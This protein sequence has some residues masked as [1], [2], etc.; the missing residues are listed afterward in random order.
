MLVYITTIK[1][2]QR[3]SDIL[4]TSGAHIPPLGHGNVIVTEMIAGPSLGEGRGSFFILNG[5]SMRFG[6]TWPFSDSLNV[7]YFP[8]RVK[9]KTC[10]LFSSPQWVLYWT[11][12]SEK[13]G[14]MFLLNFPH[15]M[16]G[17][18]TI[19]S[20][21]HPFLNLGGQTDSNR[22]SFFSFTEIVSPCKCNR[23]A[24]CF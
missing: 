4:Y 17:K 12:E 13:E 20:D 9:R 10:L 11:E 15:R 1:R 22:F 5:V 7:R 6:E 3:C 23:D 8:L 2:S 24:K 19:K 21:P 18:I 16:S 14:R